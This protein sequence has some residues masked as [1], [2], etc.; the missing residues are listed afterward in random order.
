MNGTLADVIGLCGSALFI[1]AFA[2]ANVAKS[3]N[4]SVTKL[5]ESTM[6]AYPPTAFLRGTSAFSILW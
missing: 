1:G 5:L 4:T 2:Y 6:R 3:L